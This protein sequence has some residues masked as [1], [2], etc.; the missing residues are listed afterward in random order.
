MEKIW[1]EFSLLAPGTAGRYA[2]LSE[3]AANDLSLHF[4]TEHLSDLDTER[5]ILKQILLI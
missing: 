1:S 2:C 5:Q 3:T 4:L